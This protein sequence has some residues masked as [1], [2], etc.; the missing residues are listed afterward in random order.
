MLKL[1]FVLTIIFTSICIALG[2][3]FS[4]YRAYKHKLY[5]R[6]QDERY[7]IKR[8]LQTGPEFYALPTQYLAECLDLSFDKP[9]NLYT[10]CTHSARQKLLSLPHI[11]DAKIEIIKPDTLYID[12]KARMPIAELIDYSNTGI[13]IN[14][15]L[16]P[17]DPYFTPKNL[18]QIAI[19][20]ALSEP[21]WGQQI[22][23]SVAQKIL[24]LL[25]P[26]QDI[27]QITR[28]DLTDVKAPS[29]GR[30]QIV[31]ILEDGQTRILRLTPT[32]YP[33][34]LGNYLELRKTFVQTPVILHNP[35]IIDMRI[36]N[37]AFID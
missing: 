27:F 33:Q 3:A 20:T 35:Q 19:G 24:T 34:E 15:H 2:S 8:I 7:T 22:D 30:R 13:D 4:L 26:Y 32:K 37:L 12:Y 28:I 36:E 6:T 23:I 17:L 29:A 21:I 11:A 16:F 10:F 18:P 1:R 9:T 31:L 25:A 5:R 14:G